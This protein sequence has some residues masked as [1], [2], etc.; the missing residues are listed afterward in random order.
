VRFLA[1]LVVCSPLCAQIFQIVPSTAPRGGAGS[2][3]ITFVSPAGKE[4]I[5]LQ[6]RV[7]LGAEVTAAVG[8]IVAGDAAIAVQKTLVCAPVTKPKLESLSF[9][10]ILAGAKNP[11]LNGTIF[12]VKYKV[13][14]ETTQR[15]S[16]VRVSDA[17]AVSDQR[18]RLQ[19]MHLVQTE[20]TITIR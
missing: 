5:S 2:L 8:D 4:P 18:G 11:I 16:V 20:G 19:E 13:K 12:L 17:I 1:I 14:P 10:C 3:L 9:N 6:W 15:T 7:T